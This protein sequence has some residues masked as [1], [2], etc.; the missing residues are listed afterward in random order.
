MRKE[1]TDLDHTRIFLWYEIN[2][3]NNTFDTIDKLLTIYNLNNYPTSY[4]KH[5]RPF[6]ATESERSGHR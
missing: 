6:L 2:L 3:T 1:F 4:N 5:G